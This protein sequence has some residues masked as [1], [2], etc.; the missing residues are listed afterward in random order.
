MGSSML[1]GLQILQLRI[2]L[3]MVNQTLPL[4]SYNQI[5]ASEHNGDEETVSGYASE[6]DGL[7]PVAESKESPEHVDNDDSVGA[8]CVLLRYLWTLLVTY[9]ACWILVTVFDG[10]IASSAY[11]SLS[12]Y[13]IGI[14]G[15]ELLVLLSAL[16]L[17]K[18]FLRV[19]SHSPQLLLLLRKPNS[20]QTNRKHASLLSLLSNTS[21]TA[22][23]YAFSTPAPSQS[24]FLNFAPIAAP[25]DNNSS[26]SSSNRS[27]Y[28]VTRPLLPPTMG[29]KSP[30]S[31]VYSIPSPLA[32]A[33]NCRGSKTN[34]KSTSTDGLPS[35][36]M[37]GNTCSSDACSSFA[38][39]ELEQFWIQRK[40]I[41]KPSQLFT[42]TGEL[43]Q[44][45]KT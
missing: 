18:H 35:E 6:L 15:I 23:R 42:L 29:V 9:A 11:L 38:D 32:S 19:T 20:M 22:Q 26:G 36:Q 17:L 27:E 31:V 34:S 3:T 44:R 41:V 21:A 10:S 24:V 4:F 5:S 1:L 43:G 8:I 45:S 33:N 37:Y 12:C 39:I 25:S 2:N 16:L 30:E 28:R 40:P 13:S 7:A 14:R